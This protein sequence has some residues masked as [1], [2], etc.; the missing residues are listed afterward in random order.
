MLECLLIALS[1]YLVVALSCMVL[2]VA[3]A[4]Y[5]NPAVVDWICKSCEEHRGVS[6]SFVM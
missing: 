6:G 5:A 4:L 2:I 1:P 3:F